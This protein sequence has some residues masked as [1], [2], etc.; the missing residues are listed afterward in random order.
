MLAARMIVG[1][2]DGG[3]RPARGPLTMVLEL[4]VLGKSFLKKRL[5]QFGIIALRG[6]GCTKNGLRCALIRRTRHGCSY[7]LPRFRS[8]AIF[9]RR[10][11]VL[12]IFRDAPASENHHRSG[13]SGGPADMG[14]G[15]VQVRRLR[16]RSRPP[17]FPYEGGV[18]IA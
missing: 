13:Q 4:L 7:L 15:G 5:K 6:S 14:A 16:A 10:P 11:G 12:G 18:S 3:T 8:L 17:S 2:S 9:V 1:A